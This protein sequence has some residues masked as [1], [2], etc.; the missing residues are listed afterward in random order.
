[1]AA[2]LL[3]YRSAQSIRSIKKR[4]VLQST[5]IIKADL[6]SIRAQLHMVWTTASS[7]VEIA[8]Q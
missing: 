7:A 4:N 1:M 8:V 5:V 3:H 2:K 6:A